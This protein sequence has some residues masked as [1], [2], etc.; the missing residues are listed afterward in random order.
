LTEELLSDTLDLLGEVLAVTLD[1]AEEGLSV[2][3]VLAGD[4]L[5]VTVDLIEEGFAVD[6]SVFFLEAVHKK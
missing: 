1:L 3:V 2:A 4:V 6:V 5:S